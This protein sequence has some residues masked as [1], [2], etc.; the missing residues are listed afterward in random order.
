MATFSVTDRGTFRRCRRMWDYSSNAR[1]NLAR[2]GPGAEPLELGSLIHR[3]LAAWI[4]DPKANLEM[5]F[6][7]ETNKRIDEVKEDYLFV[8]G[9]P[10]SEDELGPLLDVVPLGQAM[11]KNY[12]DFHKKPLPDNMTFAAAEQEILIPV[13]GTEH[14][15]PDCWSPIIVDVKVDSI[16][17]SYSGN[18]Y[19]ETCKGT[20]IL[21][22]Y[23]SMTL[24]GLIQEDSSGL[25]VVEHKTYSQKPQKHELER[26]DQFTGYV[27]GSTQLKIGPVIGVAYDGMWKKATIPNRRSK[28][29]PPY[30]M[31]DMFLRITI[32]KMPEQIAI[33]GANLTKEINEMANDPAIYPNIPALGCTGLNG[34]SFMDLCDAELRGEDTAGILANRYTQRKTIRIQGIR[35]II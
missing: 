30:T 9:A 28:S 3:A 19:C 27:W 10:I 2:I 7:H 11:M 15:C 8:V 31:D 35:D 24:D 14:N 17:K 16:L 34:C 1:Q 29:D 20:G 6:L 25:Y 21:Y 18:K 26:N 5:L 33:W 22:H 32:P 4:L 12:Q 23:L 13:P